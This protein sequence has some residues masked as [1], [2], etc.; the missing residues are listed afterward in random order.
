MLYYL[1]NDERENLLFDLNSRL[2]SKALAD[3]AKFLAVKLTSIGTQ[4]LR[5]TPADVLI[6]TGC[7]LP[8]T[9][10]NFPRQ[11]RRFL[12][13]F[14]EQFVKKVILFEDMHTY[15]FRSQLYEN[16]AKFDIR[17]GVSMY[18]CPEFDEIKEK[19]KWAKTVFLPHH[20]DADVFR[21]TLDSST[22]KD[23]D[24]L[25]FGD[26]GSAY[27][28]R[29]R[30]FRLIRRHLGSVMKIELVKRPKYLLS[31]QNTFTSI[32]QV[33]QHR[34]WLSG[35]INRSKFCVA[36]QSKFKYFVCKY[37]EI[38]AAGSLVVGDLDRLGMKLL[39]PDACVHLRDSMTDVEIVNEIRK[40]S[41]DDSLVAAKMQ[42]ARERLGK[43]S[44]QNDFA[45][46]LLV[47]L[48]ELG[49]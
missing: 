24:I 40:M 3:H 10:H 5:V 44:I 21:P 27:P 46:N 4:E 30:L 43:Y 29:R 37:L 31:K 1:Y 35:L 39:G 9:S 26:V 12:S 34:Q 11:A 8:C 19:H 28:F 49:V 41:Q 7:C 47:V 22:P 16:L 33:E 2:R 23:I 18:D 20:Y 36:T 13:G 14:L 6:L 15:T 32:E 38:T 25:L 42:Q 45:K 17:Y 48:G